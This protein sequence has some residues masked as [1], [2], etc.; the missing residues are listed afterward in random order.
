MPKPVVT[1]AHLRAAFAAMRWTGIAYETALEDP[2]RSRVLRAR[3]TQIAAREQAATFERTRVLERRMRADGTWV[4][5]KRSGPFTD[6]KTVLPPDDE[7]AA[8]A[9]A[10]GATKETR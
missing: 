5:W 3:A 4:T 1:D 7:A 9:P 8:T 10:E 2:I 6:Q